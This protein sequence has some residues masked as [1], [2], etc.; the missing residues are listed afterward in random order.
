MK[1]IDSGDFKKRSEFVSLLWNI[2]YRDSFAV[3]ESE[4][5]LRDL[6]GSSTDTFIR[7]AH[8]DNTTVAYVGNLFVAICVES[9][10]EMLF[11]EVIGI[12]PKKPLSDTEYC[13]D[14]FGGTR[15][16][17][18]TEIDYFTITKD[19]SGLSS[20]VQITRLVDLKDW[21]TRSE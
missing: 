15:D 1:L 14:V 7:M 2:K 17:V 18:L 6:A 4:S 12:N 19:E 5:K 11:G 13:I 3:S 9:R 20:D 10:R 8:P 16:G 21:C